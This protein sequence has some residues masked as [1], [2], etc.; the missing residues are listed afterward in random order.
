MHRS[1]DGHFIDPLRRQWKQ[2]ADLN[3]GLAI[4][5]ERKGRLHDRTGFTFGPQVTFREWLAVVL[6]ERGFRIKGI[7]VGGSTIHEQVNH[8]FRRS[9]KMCWFRSEW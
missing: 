8:A 9:L 6:S 1:N 7:D 5:L 4:R 3:A 2:I